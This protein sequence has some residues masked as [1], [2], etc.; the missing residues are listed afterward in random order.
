MHQTTAS[1]S[2]MRERCAVSHSSN[3]SGV[4]TKPL[5]YRR[6]ERARDGGRRVVLAP[7]PQA[8]PLALE[9]RHVEPA[10]GRLHRLALGQGADPGVVPP[11]VRGEEPADGAL[12]AEAAPPRR[13]PGGPVADVGAPVHDLDAVLLER[14]G[15]RQASRPGHQPPSAHGRVQPEPELGRAGAVGSVVQRAA[16]ARPA[17]QGVEHLHR[18]H[19]VAALGPAPRGRAEKGARLLRSVGPGRR[20]PAHRLGVAAL[21]HERRLVAVAVWA[22]RD[23]AVTE[24]RRDDGVGARHAPTLAE[25]A[26]AGKLPVL[27]WGHG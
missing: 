20:G 5:R 22:Q 21:L 2:A 3:V 1:P 11:A 12:D 16:E 4:R 8:H 6:S 19:P 13:T 10:V 27:G 26:W 7:R 14:I 9:H 18:P 17:G 25:G 15:D 23:H 24:H